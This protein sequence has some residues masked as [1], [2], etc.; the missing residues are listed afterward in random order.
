[1]AIKYSGTIEKEEYN[2]RGNENQVCLINNT[3]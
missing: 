3:F 1:M 2:K